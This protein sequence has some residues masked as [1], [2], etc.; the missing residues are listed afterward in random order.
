[1]RS[2]D[3]LYHASGPPVYMRNIDVI[4]HTKEDWEKGPYRSGAEFLFESYIPSTSTLQCLQAWNQVWL[5]FNHAANQTFLM[6]MHIY[7]PYTYTSHSHL[8]TC[9]CAM[10]MITERTKPH[11]LHTKLLPPL[12]YMAAPTLRM[13]VTCPRYQLYLDIKSHNS[14]ISL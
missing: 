5:S 12:T 1:M 13:T 10:H 8:T 14:W 9:N 11:P 3:D 4:Y 7:P 6:N 2:T